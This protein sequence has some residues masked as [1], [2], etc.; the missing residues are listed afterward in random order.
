M[1]GLDHFVQRQVNADRHRLTADGAGLSIDEK[2]LLVA[3]LDDVRFGI[4]GKNDLLE[5][6]VQNRLVPHGS[7]HVVAKIAWLR[8][9]SI[10]CQLRRHA[11]HVG[12]GQNPIAA[13]E[14]E[15]APFA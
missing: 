2:V 10:R 9:R 15:R 1:Q 14:D 12:M 13:Q 5:R 3:G 8:Q 4:P 6:A 7:Q 11:L